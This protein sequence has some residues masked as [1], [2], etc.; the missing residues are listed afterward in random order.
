LG[1]KPKSTEE[2]RLLHVPTREKEMQ[3]SQARTDLQPPERWKRGLREEL[4][5]ESPAHSHHHQHVH[6]AVRPSSA[7]A[8]PQDSTFLSFIGSIEGTTTTIH[9]RGL[10]IFMTRAHGAREIRDGAWFSQVSGGGGGV[11]RNRGDARRM[12][13]CGGG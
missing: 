2:S 11:R 1:T 6:V 3:L 10:V 13:T 12:W 8:L 5:L 4:L 7:A 9:K